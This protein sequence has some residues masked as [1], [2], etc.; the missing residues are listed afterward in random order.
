[1]KIK[2]H[3]IIKYNI[4]WIIQLPD[5]FFITPQVG[6]LPR[7]DIRMESESA[8]GVRALWTR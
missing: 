6:A 4:K 8:K 7:N 2:F 3:D 1:M 5:F